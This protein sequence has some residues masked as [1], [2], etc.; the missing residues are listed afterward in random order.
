VLATAES[1]IELHTSE[2]ESKPI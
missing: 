1:I 2:F